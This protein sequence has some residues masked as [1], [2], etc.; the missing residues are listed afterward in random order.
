M[1]V[2]GETDH[3]H[4]G[5]LGMVG[6]DLLELPRRH[7]DAIAHDHVG[8]AIDQR[9]ETIAVDEADV[10]RNAPVRSHRGRIDVLPSSRAEQKRRYRRGPRL[11]SPS[12]PG[13]RLASSTISTRAASIVRPVASVAPARRGNA[14]HG[15][16][17]GERRRV[18]HA[19]AGPNSCSMAV[20]MPGRDR[21]RWQARWRR[22]FASRPDSL[23]SRAI[24]DGGG[25]CRWHGARGAPPPVPTEN[26]GGGAPFHRAPGS[27]GMMA[28]GRIRECHH[29][30]TGFAPP[31]PAPCAH[32]CAA[33]PSVCT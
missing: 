7:V 32:G 3:R 2:V 5:D 1:D 8:L 20:L 9:D 18:P 31:P 30:G 6:D 13:A 17:A 27:Q 15:D 12:R 10:A 29:V 4:V 25:P 22:R 21:P 23:T 14:Q 11:T 24:T 26:N 16:G 33:R 19:I 28:R